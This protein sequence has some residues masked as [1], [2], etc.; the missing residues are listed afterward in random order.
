MYNMSCKKSLYVPV[1]SSYTAPFTTSCGSS[2]TTYKKNRILYNQYVA[3]NPTTPVCN[4]STPTARY[5]SYELKQGI[6]QGCMNQ[7]IYCVGCTKDGVQ[8]TGLA[9]NSN[10]WV[11]Q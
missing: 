9:K 3:A 11:L 5:L 7:Q 1:S 2:Y 8:M 4:T 6:Q 10:V